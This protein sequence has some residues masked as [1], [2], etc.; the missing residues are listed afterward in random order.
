LKRQPNQNRLKKPRE[1]ILEWFKAIIFDGEQ[2]R[3]RGIRNHANAARME[4]RQ[5]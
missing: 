1:S 2:A 3:T 4:R 5:A